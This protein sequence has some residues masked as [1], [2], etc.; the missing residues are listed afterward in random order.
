MISYR[1][2]EENITA[3]KKGKLRELP[4]TVSTATL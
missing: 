2:K 3:G 1:G 4:S